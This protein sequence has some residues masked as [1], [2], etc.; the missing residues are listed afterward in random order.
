MSV[1]NRLQLNMGAGGI[2]RIQGIGG[3]GG[4]CLR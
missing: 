4:Q 3:D 1:T 2:T